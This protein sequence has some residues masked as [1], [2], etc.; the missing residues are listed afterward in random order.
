M[1]PVGAASKRKEHEEGQTRKAMR[2]QR[3]GTDLYQRQ[4]PKRPDTG[5][6]ESAANANVSADETSLALSVDQHRA[7]VSSVLVERSDTPNLYLWRMSG[8]DMQT[9]AFRVDGDY[10]EPSAVLAIFENEIKKDADFESYGPYEVWVAECGSMLPIA[11]VLPPSEDRVCIGC[12]VMVEASPLKPLR[13]APTVR[14]W[15]QVEPLRR[16]RNAGAGGKLSPVAETGF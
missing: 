12:R 9:H 7:V 13:T 4:P 14:D 6:A 8:H 16:R 15:S 2:L 3:S 5:A 1:P 10:V 11:M